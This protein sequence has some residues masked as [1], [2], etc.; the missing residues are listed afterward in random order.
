[1]IKNDSYSVAGFRMPLILYKMSY[2]RSGDEIML[3]EES[4]RVRYVCYL[5][6]CKGYIST[7]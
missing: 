7:G 4:I 3:P 1:M 6:Y 2:D 5:R